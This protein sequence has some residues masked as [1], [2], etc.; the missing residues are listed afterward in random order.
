M[1]LRRLQTYNNTEPSALANTNLS[2][3]FPHLGGMQVMNAPSHSKY[4][5]LYLKAQKRFSHGLSFL[6]SFSYGKSVDNGSGVRTS[7]GDPLTPSNWLK[8]GT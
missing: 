4:H 2:R 1:H 3:P 6:S 7:V 5:A 8:C